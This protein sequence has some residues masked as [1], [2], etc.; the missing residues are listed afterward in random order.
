MGFAEEAGGRPV[1]EL[2]DRIPARLVGIVQKSS[3][4]GAPYKVLEVE[5]GDGGK[6]NLFTDGMVM[7]DY[8]EFATGDSVELICVG[9]QR[10]Y[11]QWLPIPQSG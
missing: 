2:G 10:G 6:V 4:A 3:R 11:P 9:H 5:L 7:A 8:F 1:V